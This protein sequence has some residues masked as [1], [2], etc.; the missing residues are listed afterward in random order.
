MESIYQELGHQIVQKTPGFVLVPLMRLRK[1]GT[2]SKHALWKFMGELKT[3][4]GS[5]TSL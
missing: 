1:L 5:V 2:S 3:L 4:F